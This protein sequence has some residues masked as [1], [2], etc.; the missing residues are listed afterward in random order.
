[1]DGLSVFEEGSDH[2]PGVSRFQTAISFD[3]TEPRDVGNEVRTCYWTMVKGL[4]SPAFDRPARR[5]E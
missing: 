5:W 1:M 4:A 2:A 3:P